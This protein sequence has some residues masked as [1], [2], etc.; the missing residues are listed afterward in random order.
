MRRCETCCDKSWDC[1]IITPKGCDEETVICKVCIECYM[2][3]TPD[4]DAEIKGPFYVRLE[5][6]FRVNVT[7]SNALRY[8]IYAVDLTRDWNFGLMGS[9]NKYKTNEGDLESSLKECI[10]EAWEQSDNFRNTVF[11]PK[12][13]WIKRELRFLSRKK[14]KL[15]ALLN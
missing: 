5:N 4:E 9:F 12:P 11:T 14:Q 13:E 6:I 1:E 15:E 3:M 2:F 7:T 10:M 8:F